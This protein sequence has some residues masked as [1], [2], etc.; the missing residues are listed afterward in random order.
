[1]RTVYRWWSVVLFVLVV[2]QVGLA[3]Y[4][5]FYAAN[6][7]EDEGATIDEDVFFDGFGL[8]A[9]MGYLVILAGLVFLVIGVIAGYGR[10]RLGWHG[11]LAGLLILQILLAWFGF[12]VPAVFGFLH[13]VNALLIFAI[14]GWLA[15]TQWHGRRE[16]P[17][18]A[19]T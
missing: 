13:P 3:G 14:S 15:W 4:G 17:P 9:G 2:V 1:M 19:V 18:A 5:A 8:H 11:S 6:K 16:L 10:W 12:E 7:L